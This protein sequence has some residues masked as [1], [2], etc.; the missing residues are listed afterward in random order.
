[1]FKRCVRIYMVNRIVQK[2]KKK[3]NRTSMLKRCVR[4]YMVNTVLNRDY[5]IAI[6]ISSPIST[7]DGSRFD[8][9]Y[10]IK[11]AIS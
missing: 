3:K 1:M 5:Y 7:R 4:M 6:F 8:M 10:D 11:I 9:G 2:K